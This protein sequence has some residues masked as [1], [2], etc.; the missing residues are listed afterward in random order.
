MMSGKPIF[1]RFF[2]HGSP[3]SIDKFSYEF[4]GKGTDQMGS[5][6]YFT[7]ERKEAE[8]YCV[9]K[10]HNSAFLEAA[11]NPTL[12][13]VKLRISNP[14]LSTTIE[15]LR[16]CRVKA[17][18]NRSPNLSERLAD[19]GDPDFEGLDKLMSYAAESMTGHDESPLIMTLNMI[20]T[21]F[22]GDHISEFNAAVRDILG[23]DGLIAD[24]GN[25]H[26]IA[27]AWFPEQIEIV[28]RITPRDPS[29]DYQ[30]EVSP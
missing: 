4:A 5:G 9:L 13:K 6:F 24:A 28:S 16:T 7:T 1:E 26:W 17:L 30:S 3:C 27:V 2:Y 14:L 22:F 11:D 15:P 8:K 23:Y 10:R 21:D 12:H 20:A 18:M 29:I 19:Y 25:K